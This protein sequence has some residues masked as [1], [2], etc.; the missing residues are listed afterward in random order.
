MHLI[1]GNSNILLAQN[2]A[3]NLNKKLTLV[4][5]SKFYGGE[6]HVEL[7]NDIKFNEDFIIFQ[8]LINPVND[9]IFELLLIA[10]ALARKGAKNI[11]AI[12]PYL[13][14][15]RQ[16]RM[17]GESSSIGLSLL[18]KMI[19]ININNLIV[20]DLHSAASL[21]FFD[22]PVINIMLDKV[23]S[24]SILKNFIKNDLE[25]VI[26]LAADIG[27][28]PRA[29]KIA[30]ILDL[31]LLPIYKTRKGE[32]IADINISNPEMISSKNCIIIDDIVDSGKT[33]IS[34]IDKLSYYGSNSITAYCT[35]AIFN[36]EVKKQLEDSKIDKLY[37]TN[38]AIQKPVLS[39]KISII[40]IS[41]VISEEIKNLLSV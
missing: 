16:D 15:S 34:I 21:G 40:D 32:E 4:K 23:I 29:K 39:H 27:S 10:D 9:N 8:N 11:T 13:A 17:L 14:Y 12:V 37:S 3:K 7:P 20:V 33:L 18:A 1:S 35:H 38:T 2:I 25:N 22:I 24:T 30:D 36:D 19:S 5:T 6:I 31:P 41:H 28:I 26:I